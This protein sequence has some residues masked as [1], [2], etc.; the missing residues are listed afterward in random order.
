V[1]VIVLTSAALIAFA[2]NSILCRAALGQQTIDAAS[3]STIRLLAGALCLW[4]LVSARRGWRSAVRGS[5]ASAFLLFLYAIP[6]SYAFG[7]LTTGTGSLILFGAVQ[8][9]MMA[10]ALSGGERPHARQWVGLV[11]AIAGLV[12]LVSPGLAAPSPAGAALMSVAGAAWG[13]YSLRGRGAADPLGETGG[14]FARAV[15]LAVVVSLLAGDRHVT[16]LGLTL[17]ATSG[18]VASGLGY[19]AWYAALP[20]LSA[21]RAALVQL[22]VPVLAAFGGL[23]A[24]GESLSWRLIGS[25]ILVLGGIAVALSARDRSVRVQDSRLRE[26][27]IRS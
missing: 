20:S 15:P 12:Y 8:L 18:A 7:L 19:V 25:A 4:M 16:A 1:R 26:E 5:W 10:A 3:F 27:A 11:A 14:N 2:S 24:M 13:V 17:A 9:T 21:T 22:I 23:M 6:F